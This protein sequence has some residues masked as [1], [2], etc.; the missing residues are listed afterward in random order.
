MKARHSQ[1][2]MWVPAN[3][4][5]THNTQHSTKKAWKMRLSGQQCYCK[6]TLGVDSPVSPFV[7][8]HQGSLTATEVEEPPYPTWEMSPKAELTS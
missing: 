6:V 4:K 3:S 2:P 7:P 5:Y 8:C 1:G